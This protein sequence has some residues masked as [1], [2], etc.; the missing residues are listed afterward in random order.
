MAE[1]KYTIEY[2]KTGR[3]KCADAKCKQVIEKE[4]IRVGKVTENPFNEGAESMTKYYHYECVFSALKRARANTKRIE[5]TDDLDGFGDLKSDDQEKV[6]NVL[7]ASKKE[8]DEAPKEKKKR[9]A[10][11]KKKKSDEDDEEENDDEDEE[12]SAKKQKTEE[13]ATA[14][15]SSSSSED[16]AYYVYL[17]AE[18]KAGEKF[19]EC[20][21]KGTSMTVRYG[22]IG[23]AGASKTNNY[24]TV[25]L[26]IKEAKKNEKKKRKE[27]KDGD[28]TAA[29]PPKEKKP[30]AKKA[31][32]GAGKKKKKSDDDDD[33]DGGDDGDD[34]NDGEDEDKDASSG[35]AGADYYKY[36]VSDSSSGGKFWEVTVRGSKM[37][38]RYGKVDSKG[39]SSSKDCGSLE[40]AKKEAI[41]TE[42]QKL[43]KGYEE[44]S[45][46][47]GGGAANSSGGDDDKEEDGDEDE[48]AEPEEA[49]DAEEE[50]DGGDDE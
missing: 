7:E 11:A 42:N 23:S 50:E 19:W 24:D 44:K 30:R 38:T 14:S 13:S 34:G 18:S 6:K 22:K 45:G 8:A 37:T 47:G 5:S 17:V 46:G 16:K 4:T 40:K 35:G 39:Q 31:A 41:K 25:E 43:K 12:K 10:P 33:E 3:S 15:S 9:K 21:V 49:E 29:P 36:L 48:E 28:P 1:N 2:A 20:T 32:A 27:Y 26:A